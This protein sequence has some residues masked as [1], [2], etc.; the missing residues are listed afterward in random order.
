MAKEELV[1]GLRQAVS[2]GEP[3]E[4][5]MMSFYNAGYL[6]GDIEAAA[7]AMVQTQNYSQSSSP[8]PI[9]K[10]PITQPMSPIPKPIPT[11]QN[12]S[13]VLQNVSGYGKK[14]S[15]RGTFA[16]IIL[17]IMLLLLLG[18]LMG[19]ILFKDELLG[20]FESLFWRVLF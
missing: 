4:K 10:Q 11:I 13:V 7:A 1:E 15:R 6:K 18:A 12:Q 20:Y 19:V 2:K 5:A 14:P 3:L 17:F 8:A 16:T 9:Q